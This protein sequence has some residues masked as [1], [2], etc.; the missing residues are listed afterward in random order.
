MM[1]LAGRIKHTLDVAIQRLH[2]ANPRKHRR[3]AERRD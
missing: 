1:L 3:P 2:D